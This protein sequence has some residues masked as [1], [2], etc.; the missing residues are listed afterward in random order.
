MGNETNVFD[1]E[2]ERAN[3]NWDI[4]ADYNFVD[5]IRKWA[6]DRTKLLAIIEHPDEEVEKATYREVWDDAMR[7][8]NILRDSGIHK[9]DRVMILFPRGLDVYIA[10]IGIWAIGAV[11][12]PGTVMLRRDDIEYRLLNA[13]IKALVTNDMM[14]ADEMDSIK[15]KVPDVRLFFSSYMAGWSDYRCEMDSASRSLDREELIAS[16][17]LAINYTSGTTG[18]PKGVLHTH[19]QMYCFERLNRHYWWNTRPYE[20]CWATTEPG[21]AKW[22]WAPFGAIL[23]GGATNFHY[24]GR[25][26][27]EKWFELLDKWRVNR[28]CMTATE[29]RAMAAIDGADRRYD[30]EELKVIL[31]AGEPCTPGIIRY[32]DEKFGSDVREGYGQTETCVI[33]CT[34]PGME[35]R[36][37][38]MGR[39]TPGVR[40]AIVDPD[41]G[42]EVPAG[43][44]GVIAVEK[45]HPMLFKGYHGQP[46]RTAECFIG[47]WYLT[48]DLATMDEDGYI[49]FDSRADDVCIS[50]GYRIGPFEVESAVNSHEAVLESSMI[51]SPEPLRGEVVK[52]LVVL[53]EGYEPSEELVHDIQQHVKDITAPYKYPREIEFVSELPK[54]ISGKIKRKELRTMEFEKKRDV[55]EKLKEKGLWERVD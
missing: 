47:N 42:E 5:V 37:G 10:S 22:Y 35:I 16:D 23:N 54:T 20:L 19:S 40:G 52:V 49:W 18:A 53:K 14:V 55:I 21:W 17:L 4:P 6:K 43:S 31:T 29:L 24:T 38:S 51:P 45:D 27:P 41:T 9:G 3:F 11:V 12:V 15:D 7:F 32:F 8:G 1:Y 33:A 44:V 13:G 48:G 2:E 46:E 39:F 28:A 25:F 36:P 26:E 30:L 34:L 50:S